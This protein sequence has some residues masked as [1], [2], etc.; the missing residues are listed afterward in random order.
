[1]QASS[2]D[3]G[4]LKAEGE[5]DTAGNSM[6]RGPGYCVWGMGGLNICLGVCEWERR[7]AG[8]EAAG[9]LRAL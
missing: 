6:I 9:D 2:D 1:M 8:G 4:F 5:E 7:L 3:R